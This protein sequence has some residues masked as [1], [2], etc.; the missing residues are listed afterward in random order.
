MKDQKKAE[1]LFHAITDVP[2]AM[3]EEAAK[4]KKTA[5]KRWAALAAC[6]AAAVG[7]GA[8]L[9]TGGDK[10]P[11]QSPVEPFANSLSAL[12]EVEYPAARDP[13]DYEGRR[14]VRED[15]P[16]EDS[17]LDA[18]DRFA[19][20]TSAQVLGNQEGNRTY[21][22]LS[23]YYALALA[24]SGAEGETEVELLSLL[25]VSDRAELT[26]QCGNL[27]RQIYAD[28]EINALS[29]GNSLWMA[30]TVDW[31]RAFLETA[32]RQFYSSV[33]AADFSDPRTGEA[34]AGWVAEQSRGLLVPAFETNPEQILSI[35]NTVYFHDEW[36]D[37]FRAENT[38][39]DTFH[40]ADGGTVKCDFMSR[41][42]LGGFAV[43]D[44]F[45]QSSLQLKE[46]GSMVFI[47]PDEGVSISELLSSPERVETMFDPPEE[48]EH[49]GE[50][51]WKIP[52]FQY[53]TALDLAGTVQ[54]LGV[55]SAFDP[56]R[57]DFSG[58]TSQPAWFDTLR[59]ETK[60]SIDEHGV[61]AA[62]YTEL[63]YAGAGMPEDKAELILD[64]PFLYGIV[65]RTGGLLFVGVCENPAAS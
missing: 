52:K 65:S 13:D 62:A 17:F 28:N 12:V 33:Y 63:R 14:A 26:E 48:L 20:Q 7:L 31:N 50:I 44:G 32:A 2:D 5:W 41:C 47:L 30:E 34:M 51:T 36:I 25:G 10:P 23:L 39:P 54:A 38:A 16:L 49:D 55:T 56:E 15:N 3:V 4:P 60:I 1:K 40:L 22:P 46:S 29:I 8:V 57:A 27:Y 42:T 53:S 37:E 11:V 6:A 61:E 58:I 59:Q 45:L 18:L 35:L 21:S 9:W 24:A 43:G 19:Y 64:R